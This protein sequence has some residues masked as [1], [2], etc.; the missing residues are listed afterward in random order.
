[1]HASSGYN[2]RRSECAEACAALGIESL[3]EATPED[4]LRLPE[5]LEMRARHVLDENARVLAAV[6][7]LR[8][9]EI[10]ELAELL[11][12]SHASL[13]DLYQVSTPAVEATVEKLLRAGAAGARLIGGGFGGSVL[14]LIE[15]GLPLPSDSMEVVPGPGAHILAR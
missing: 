1:V 3:R 5:P 14:G 9:G 4:L 11:S 13:R 2:E 7:A 12:A 6:A 15:P 10:R 8:A